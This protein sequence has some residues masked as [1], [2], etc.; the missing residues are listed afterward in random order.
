[1]KPLSIINKN[2]IHNYCRRR[3][4]QNLTPI[5]SILSFTIFTLMNFFD[6]LMKLTSKKLDTGEQD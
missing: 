3:K 4:L 1:M 6:A 5:I 2:S